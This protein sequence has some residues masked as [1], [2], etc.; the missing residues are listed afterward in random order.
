M[1]YRLRVEL[2]QR[3]Q[4]ACAASSSAA[5][6]RRSYSASPGHNVDVVRDCR[7]QRR[8][9]MV[10]DFQTVGDR[11]DLLNSLPRADRPDALRRAHISGGGL[12]ACGMAAADASPV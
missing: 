11:P 2:R 3:F 10:A 8:R 9:G 12:P 4:H 6:K 5:A 1:A 7:R